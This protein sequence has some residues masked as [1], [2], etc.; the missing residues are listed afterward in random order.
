MRSN[1]S[2]SAILRDPTRTGSLAAIVYKRLSDA[3]RLMK[4]RASRFHFVLRTCELIK[5]ERG[6]RNINRK[7][8]GPIAGARQAAL[9]IGGSLETDELS[10]AFTFTGANELLHLHKMN[11]R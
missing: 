5:A 10:F 11:R 4:K 7:N 6:D 2:V 9:M 8:S 1:E 3:R